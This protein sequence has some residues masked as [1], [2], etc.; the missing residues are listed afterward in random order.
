MQ[1]S[2]DRLVVMSG[3]GGASNAAILAAINAGAQAAGGGELGV[4]SAALFVDRAASLHQDAALHPDRRDRRDRSHHPQGAGAADGPGAALRTPSARCDRTRGGRC[5]HHERDRDAHASDQHA[6]VC[7]PGRGSRLLRRNLRCIFVASGL[8]A[9]RRNPLRG[10]RDVPCQE[11]SAR[12]G[13][14]RGGRCG[15]IGCSI[16]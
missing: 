10:R 3:L 11:P 12:R 1:G 14:A 4:W 2:L 5:R 7:R 9:E 8:C 13:N 6:R 16:V 15:T